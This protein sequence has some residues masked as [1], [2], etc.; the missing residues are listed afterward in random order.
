MEFKRA[1]EILLC[2][3]ESDLRFLANAAGLDT[4]HY[5]TKERLAEGLVVQLNIPIPS[6]WP[7]WRE[8]PNES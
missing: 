6:D 8:I 4:H 5:N 1:H 7:R 3:E 2:L